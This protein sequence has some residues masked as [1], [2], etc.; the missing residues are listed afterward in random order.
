MR[1]ENRAKLL[2]SKYLKGRSCDEFTVVV[3]QNN[4]DAAKK[5]YER[6]GYQVSIVSIY[7]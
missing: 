5:E 3:T 2:C 7:Y 6:Q 1:V 4:R